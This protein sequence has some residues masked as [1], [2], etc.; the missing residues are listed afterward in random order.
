M[1]RNLWYLPC[2]RC[3]LQWACKQWE[4][5]AT[6]TTRTWNQCFPASPG[7]HVRYLWPQTCLCLL[8]CEILHIL[9]SS[10]VE[11]ALMNKICRRD[12]TQTVVKTIPCK[13]WYTNTA[14]K[15][16]KIKA[17]WSYSK[18]NLLVLIDT[19]QVKTF[20]NRFISSQGRTESCK[21]SGILSFS[22]WWDTDRQHSKGKVTR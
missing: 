6:A 22:C 13:H 2:W 20:I 18:N 11:K 16:E 21:D 19:K 1:L 8:C 10:V 17:V 14:W 15:I 5:K 3:L 9:I 12:N 4:F 7:E